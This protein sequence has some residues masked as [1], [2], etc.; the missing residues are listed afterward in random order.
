MLSENKRIMTEDS[1]RSNHKIEAFYSP[2]HKIIY[3]SKHYPVYLNT[4]PKYVYQYKE[5]GRRFGHLLTG[6]VLYNLGRMSSSQRSDHYI[7]TPG[8]ICKLGIREP[9]G[10]YEE[11]ITDCQLMSS[12]IWEEMQNSSIVNVN[13][14]LNPSLNNS[15]GTI[16]NKQTV[17]T[18]DMKG[19]SIKVSSETSCFIIR[20]ATDSLMLNKP[21][22]CGLLEAYALQSFRNGSNCNIPV[23]NLLWLFLITYFI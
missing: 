21:V 18:L 16:D 19:S 3:G 2:P 20:V 23:I 14:V 22:E 8:E 11:T 7:G 5:S 9:S 12:F 15:N 4:P 17:N 1:Q 10:D 13:T 6:L